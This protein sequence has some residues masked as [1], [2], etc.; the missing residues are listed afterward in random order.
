MELSAWAALSFLLLNTLKHLLG[1]NFQQILSGEAQPG[2]WVPVD[3]HFGL[4]RSYQRVLEMP[5]LV[6]HRFNERHYAVHLR[7]TLLLHISVIIDFKKVQLNGG[8]RRALL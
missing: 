3:F 2:T 7:A 6:G 8:K 5:L 4:Y 1:I